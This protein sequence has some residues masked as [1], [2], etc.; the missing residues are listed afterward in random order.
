MID[1]IHEYMYDR[2]N[3]STCSIDGRDNK[4]VQ[5]R[6]QKRN[7]QKIPNMTNIK[8]DRSINEKK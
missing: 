2:L 3:D 8:E 6:K 5:G 1:I 4:H 7:G